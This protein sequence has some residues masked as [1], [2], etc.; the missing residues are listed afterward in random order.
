MVAWWGPSKPPVGHILAEGHD[1]NTIVCHPQDE[2]TMV[3]DEATGWIGYL[4]KQVG[5]QVVD[6]YSSSGK[7]HYFVLDKHA[8]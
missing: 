6:I 1:I 2:N 7:K 5:R 8:N 3:A 4:V